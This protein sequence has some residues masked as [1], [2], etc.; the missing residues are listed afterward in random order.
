MDFKF[1]IIIPVT[2]NWKYTKACLDSI[3]SKYPYGITI[4]DGGSIDETLLALKKDY[5]HI[6]VMDLGRFDSVAHSWNVGI[7]D[8]FADPEIQSVY[9]LNNDTILLPDTIDAL[10]DY[11][12]EHPDFLFLQSLDCE[13][14]PPIPFPTK[15]VEMTDKFA[16]FY[17]MMLWRKC[18]EIVGEFEEEYEKAYFEDMSYMLRINETGV[19]TCGLWTSSLFHHNGITSNKYR[20]GVEFDRNLHYFNHKWQKK[21]FMRIVSRPHEV[22]GQIGRDSQIF[23][24]KTFSRAEKKKILWISQTPLIYNGFGKVTDYVTKHLSEKY[25]T[26]ILAT[27]GRGLPHEHGK[28]RLYNSLDSANEYQAFQSLFGTLKPSIVIFL[29]PWHGIWPYIENILGSQQECRIF[30]YLSPAIHDSMPIPSYFN[31]MTHIAQ[32]KRDFEVLQKNNIPAEFIPHGVNTD[33]YYSITPEKRDPRFSFLYIGRNESRKRLDRLLAAFA[34]ASKEHPMHLGL[35]CSAQPYQ[36]Q[37][38]SFNLS[39]LIRKYKIGNCITLHNQTQFQREMSEK[40]QARIINQYDCS[41]SASQIESF[42]LPI[43]EGFAC[44]KPVV[45]P[46]W[47][48]PGWLASEGRGYAAKIQTTED[49]TTGNPMALV[50]VEDMAKGMLKM[51]TDSL[52]YQQCSMNA[53]KFAL[54]HDWKRIESQWDSLMQSI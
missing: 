21:F 4:V 29:Y 54:A 24:V 10:I 14:N 8:A 28:C 34:L 32:N 46:D 53:F 39:D 5:Q 3:Q 25:E 35:Q 9:I 17:G 49:H 11:H 48:S 30:N 27:N 38:H 16:G 44:A 26:T 19:K 7:R 50:D 47:H 51:A 33:I 20:Y 36:P 42:G 41:V 22:T 2:D 45:C 6:K 43:L 40:M 13:K 23:K 12:L 31:L 52:Y 15:L 18:W 37:Y 1:Q